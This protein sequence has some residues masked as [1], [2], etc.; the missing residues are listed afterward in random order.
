MSDNDVNGPQSP[1]DPEASWETIELVFGED[2]E[3][4]LK[5]PQDEVEV[6]IGQFPDEMQADL[7]GLVQQFRGRDAP[8]DK[9]L[10]RKEE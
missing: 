6:V 10:K 5:A 9:F 2:A 3:W 4:W 7:R 8:E 1:W